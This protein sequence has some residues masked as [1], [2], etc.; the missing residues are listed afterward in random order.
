MKRFTFYLAMLVVICVMVGQAK[1]NFTAGPE[2]IGAPASVIDDPPGATNDHQQGFNEQQGVTLLADLMVDGG[3]IPA[4]T[5]VNSHMIFLNTIG[6][7][8]WTQDER[9]TWTFD[10]DI[11]GVMS[12]ADGTLEAA[13]SSFLG[14]PGTTYP[15]AFPCRGMEPEGD[16]YVVSGNAITV[17]MYVTEPGDWIRVV[18]QPIPAPGAIVLG[19]VGVGL[20][21]WLRRRRI[22]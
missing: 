21:G 2:I 6:G 17:T 7:Q 14:A 4:G 3:F 18:A 11:L 9:K 19:S 1:A 13:S 15:G 10:G 22:L 12:D 16:G 8:V 20:I 5:V